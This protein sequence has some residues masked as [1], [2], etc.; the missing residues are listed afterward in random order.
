[1][2]RIVDSNK[3][4]GMLFDRARGQLSAEDKAAG[5]S[6]KPLQDMAQLAIMVEMT[7][8]PPYLTALYSISDPN[9]E[10]YQLLRSVMM[11]EMF[12]INQAANL[13]VAIGGRPKMTGSFTPTY[14]CYLPHANP[15]TT[16]FIGLC[17]ASVEVFN[18]TFTAIETPAPPHALPRGNN[19]SY[20]AQL[21]DMLLLCLEQYSGAQPLFE[22][23]PDAAQRID[24]YLGKFGGKPILVTDLASAQLGVQQIV[25]QGE[26]SVPESQSMIPIEPWATYN[27]YGQRTDGTYGPIIGSP[28]ELSHFKKF[29]T[30]SLDRDRFPPTYPIISNPK[31]SDFTNPVALELAEVFDLAYSVM[32]DSME[33]SFSSRAPGANDT[34]FTLALPLMHQALP[35]IARQLMTT[36]AHAN[37]NS[38]VGPNGA[39]TYLYQPGSNLAA[40]GKRLQSSVGVVKQNI[41]DPADREELVDAL[42]SVRANIDQL[43]TA[44]HI[45]HA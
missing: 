13:M 24:I 40:L 43:A 19:Y 8:I 38:D 36:P 7:T 1:M 41:D 3:P 39:P 22:Q 11:E 15:D 27:G 21:Y 26:G 28:Y 25:Q 2:T 35:T 5:D 9:T 14:P 45:R 30:V 42:E 16:P 20:I 33:R 44:Q 29:R 32:L 31:R 37:T 4:F 12:H 23:N 10:A 6:R 18:D 34:F 17:R